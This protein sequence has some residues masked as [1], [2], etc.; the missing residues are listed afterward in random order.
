MVS[1]TVYSFKRRRVIK[2]HLALN[3]R[4]IF[5]NEL[6][7]ICE[8]G[9]R[10]YQQNFQRCGFV[11]DNGN[12]CI[13]FASTHIEHC[14]GELKVA[15][16][17]DDSKYPVNLTQALESIEDKFTETYTKVYSTDPGDVRTLP[18]RP[19]STMREKL[20]ALGLIKMSDMWLRM[21][22]NK[23]CFTCLQSVPDHVMPCGH[24]YCEECV[25]EIGRASTD[26]ESTIVVSD[27]ALCQETFRGGYTQLVRIRPRCAGVKVLALDGGGV[28]GIIE[29]AILDRLGLRTGLGVRVTDMFDL[30][31]GTSTGKFFDRC[32]LVF[33][34][35][36]SGKVF[37]ISIRCGS[38]VDLEL[39]P[40]PENEPA[41]RPF[42]QATKLPYISGSAYQVNTEYS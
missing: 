35:H 1:V 41:L 26:Y 28:R 9:L 30:I 10:H 3:P 12:R 24:V 13:S 15:G 2:C 7:P 40:A 31:M 25:K 38:R 11:F 29:L 42:P 6:R 33:R 5:R 16:N 27:C 22:S 18:R 17:F 37:P 32:L 20:V 4:T 14:Y 34:F 39:N 36:L 23:T 8:E 19:L 21:K